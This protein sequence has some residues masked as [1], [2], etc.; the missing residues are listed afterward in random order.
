MLREDKWAYIQDGEEAFEGIEL[1]DAVND[2][3]QFTNLAGK[4][5]SAPVVESLKARFAAKLRAVRDND[6]AKVNQW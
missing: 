5:D 1:F 3:Q 6:L 4:A 2:P